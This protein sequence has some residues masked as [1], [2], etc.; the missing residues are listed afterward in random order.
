MCTPCNPHPPLPLLLACA[1]QGWLIPQSLGLQAFSVPR[2]FPDLRSLCLVEC[3]MLA[4]PF[5]T[6]LHQHSQLTSLHL[7][8]CHMPPDTAAALS[9]LTVLSQLQTQKKLQPAQAGEL[10]GVL[11]SLAQLTQLTSLAL[12]YNVVTKYRA[13]LPSLITVPSKMVNLQSLEL[14]FTPRYGI[15][16]DPPCA[17]VNLELNSIW[18]HL[19]IADLQH[20]LISNCALTTL[21]LNGIVLDQAGLDLLLAHPQINN[22]KLLAIA[23]TA[24]RVDSPCSWHTLTLARQVDVRTVAYVPCTRSNT[25]CR[26][27]RCCCHL[28][29][30]QSSYLSCLRQ[31]QHAWQLTAPVCSPSASHADH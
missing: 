1:L 26:W 11:D 20:L 2:T 21:A 31:P 29:Q 30:Q 22:V 5:I 27:D 18:D 24:S 17:T 7:T 23:A 4:E 6:T 19:S 10:Q 15:R 16:G 25:P 28:T 9:S 3:S 13:P 12:G 14:E 8:R